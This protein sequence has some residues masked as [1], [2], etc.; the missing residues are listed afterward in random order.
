VRH[1][2]KPPGAAVAGPSPD[3]PATC[4]DVDEFRNVFT[5]FFGAPPDA[6]EFGCP[7][8]D[9]FARGAFGGGGAGLFGDGFGADIAPSTPSTTEAPLTLTLE[10]LFK[11]V[12]P[13]QGLPYPTLP[14]PTLA[15]T[16]ALPAAVNAGARLAVCDAG[17][18]R[19]L[20]TAVMASGWRQALCCW[21]RRREAPG[22][23]P[24]DLRRRQWRERA[25]ARGGD[26]PRPARLAGGPPVRTNKTQTLSVSAACA[27]LRAKPS[28]LQ[29]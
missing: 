21:R 15:S 10:E 6:F 23:E 27:R 24:A 2:P 11:G 7:R 9:L 16:R 14:Y 26:H 5:E 17:G 19:V 29:A 1:P 25:R 28:L 22:A 18:G 8:A 12:Q 3:R 13:Y 4:V 20:D